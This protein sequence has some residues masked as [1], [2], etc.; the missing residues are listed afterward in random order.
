M[1]IQDSKTILPALK[2]DLSITDNSIF[3]RWLEE[4]KKYLEGLSQEPPEETLQMEYW[5]RL[6]QLEASR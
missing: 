4:E 3:H 5:Q 1:I 2:R 6:G